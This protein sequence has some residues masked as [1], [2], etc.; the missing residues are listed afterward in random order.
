MSDEL[1]RFVSGP[2]PYSSW[3]LWLAILLS[4]ILIGWYAA[5]F[6]FT[7]PERRIRDLPVIGAAR[8]E[9]VKRRSARAVRAIGE[10]YRAGELAA[11]PAAAAVSR[12]LRAFLHAAT[13]SRAEYMQVDAIAA[14]E[15][16]SAAPVLTE[17]IDAQF[18]ADS[19][20]DVGAVTDS[21]EELIHTWS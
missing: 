16:A 14:G 17:L 5:V 21:A 2:T 13:G 11:A 6:L 10:R 4:V 1:I 8:S 3:W 20:I 7:M 12:E 15:L 9:L 18:N 19:T